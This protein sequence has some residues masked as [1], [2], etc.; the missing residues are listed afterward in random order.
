M[1]LMAGMTLEYIEA[2][3]ERVEAVTLDEVNAAVEAVL[4]DAHSVTS[5][6]K[7]EPTS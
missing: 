4:E 6:L 7:Q 5:V 2:W 1:A 3:P